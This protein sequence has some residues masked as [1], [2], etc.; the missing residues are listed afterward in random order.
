M[1]FLPFKFL[2]NLLFPFQP[3]IP[4]NDN[5]GK[6]LQHLSIIYPPSLSYLPEAKSIV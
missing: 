2:K 6:A 5:N 1:S 4:N 3:H